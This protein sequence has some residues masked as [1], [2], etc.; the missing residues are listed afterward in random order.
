MKKKRR[1]CG[2]AG[3]TLDEVSCRKPWRAAAGDG[4][5]SCVAVSRSGGG[6]GAGGGVVGGGVAMC[7][8]ADARGTRVPFYHASPVSFGAK[9]GHRQ[10]HHFRG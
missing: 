1:S 9:D 3:Q 2:G 6:G 7:G 10:R 8:A 4:G 5:E